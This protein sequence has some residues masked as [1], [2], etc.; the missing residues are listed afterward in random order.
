MPKTGEKRGRR[1]GGSGRRNETKGTSARGRG[2]RGEEQVRVRLRVE[3]A[4]EEEEERTKEEEEEEGGRGTLTLEKA[5]SAKEP[6]SPPE[7]PAALAG[8]TPVPH[9]AAHP[10]GAS[11]IKEPL[12]PERPR[13]TAAERETKEEAPWTSAPSRGPLTLPL[14]TL[15]LSP[16]FPEK[17]ERKRRECVRRGEEGGE[18]V[19]EQTKGARGG[20]EQVRVR[21]RVEEAREEEKERTKEEEEEEGGRGTLTL[22]KAASAKEPCSPPEGPAALAGSTPVPHSAVHQVGASEIKE[23]LGPERSRPTAA[24]RET[25]EEA[26]WASAPSRGPLTLPLLTLSLSPPFPDKKERKRR[27]CVRRG[28]EGGE[29]VGEETKGARGG[30]EQV[31]V[32]LRVEEERE[33]E[34]ERTK[35]KKRKKEAEEH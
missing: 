25:K 5:A 1:G 33:E 13:P 27:E 8:S 30:E 12:G 14:L 18:G 21:L 17:K 28:E 2:A 31:R 15:S 9:S 26:P 35:K 3:E 4:R 32:R 29:G 19:G 6:C 34:K 22:E 10:V 24:E 16:P 23:P 7:G 20:E 11:E